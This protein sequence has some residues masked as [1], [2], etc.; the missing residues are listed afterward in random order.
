M[1]H[2]AR[3]VALALSVLALS[4]ACDDGVGGD[5]GGSD[6]AIAHDAAPAR[7][8]GNEGRDAGL[9]GFDAGGARDAGGATTIDPYDYQ[10]TGVVHA[11][12]AGMPSIILDHIDG[13]ECGDTIEVA[14]GT[15]Q[16]ITLRELSGCEGMPIIVQPAAGGEVVLTDWGI[17]LHAMHHVIVRARVR[18]EHPFRVTAPYRAAVS[19]SESSTDIDLSGTHADGC[20]YGVVVKT[21][22]ACDVLDHVAPM[23]IEDIRIHHNLIESTFYEGMYLG[24]Y[25]PG[26][27]DVTCGGTTTTVR[28]ERLARV[29][30]FDNELHDTGNDALKLRL[31]V[32]GCDLHDNVISG[33]G[34]LRTDD[35]AWCFGITIGAETWGRIYG[36]VI[37]HGYCSAIDVR[38]NDTTHEYE[39]YDN[40]TRFGGT[41]PNGAQGAD[42]GGGILYNVLADDQRFY[43]HDNTSS[44]HRGA[45]LEVTNYGSRPFM[46]R[47]CRNGDDVTLTPGSPPLTDC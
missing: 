20:G 39:I 33:Y 4:S 40:T 30:V 29:E 42:W 28:A 7:D 12:G 47:A 13:L 15:Y 11:I 32:D 9:E 37:D 6:G 31:C 46:G 25:D 18:G 3:H 26:D 35:S 16:G 1:P 2:A 19:I 17:E 21:D 44:D 45:D 38:T 22:P 27:V 8:G 41:L 24:Y 23:R 34:V 10:G 14:P 5:A 43:I 36:N